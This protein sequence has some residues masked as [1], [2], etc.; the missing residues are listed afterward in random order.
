MAGTQ[1]FLDIMARDHASAVFNKV[2]SSA[3]HLSKRTDAAGKRSVAFGRVSR[4]VFGGLSVYG[5]GMFLRFVAQRVC[6]G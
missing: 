2:A 6:R 5:V 3:D 4:A 1:L